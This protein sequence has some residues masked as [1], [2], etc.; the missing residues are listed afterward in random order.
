MLAE[1]TWGER[2]LDLGVR[3]FQ[4]HNK[5][6]QVA[7]SQSPQ[8]P[9]QHQGLCPGYITVLPAYCGEFLCESSLSLLYPKH[10]SSLLLGLSCLFSQLGSFPGLLKLFVKLFHQLP[11]RC[12]VNFIVVQLFALLFSLLLSIL[13]ACLRA[14]PCPSCHLQLL[15]QFCLAFF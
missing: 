10:I 8:G 13:K 14:V 9:Q 2:S 3:E 11:L 12:Q 6:S 7:L 5:H 15:E 4:D 1:L